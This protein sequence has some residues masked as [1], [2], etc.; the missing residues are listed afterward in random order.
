MQRQLL[1][2]SITIIMILKCCDANADYLTFPE[3]G[4]LF[5]RVN[6][7]YNYLCIYCKAPCIRPPLLCTIFTRR[8]G[9]AFTRYCPLARRYSIL[10]KTTNMY[11][12]RCGISFSCQVFINLSFKHTHTLSVTHT[13]SDTHTELCYTD[14]DKYNS[15]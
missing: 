14:N 4:F 11:V 3:S 7:S 2:L 13:H 12:V 8:L 1:A 5:R 9:W 15:Y 6:V 10:Y